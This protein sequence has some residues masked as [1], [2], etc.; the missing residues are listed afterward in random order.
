MLKITL[1][2]VYLLASCAV[3]RLHPSRPLLT[4]CE[5]LD[6]GNGDIDLVCFVDNG[7]FLDYNEIRAFTQSR[8]DKRKFNVSI[9]CA[10]G[11]VLH[12]PWPFSAV[13]VVSLQVTGCETVGFISEM[14]E[15]YPHPNEIKQVS[16]TDITHRITIKELFDTFRTHDSVPSEF[17]CGLN[18]AIVQVFK[19]IKY[20]FPPPSGTIEELR[21][22]EEL[23]S[24]NTMEKLLSHNSICR[25]PYLQYL[26]ESGHSSLSSLRFKL[27]EAT[28]LY[29]ELRYYVLRNNSLI[30]VPNEFRNLA[31]RFLPKLEVLDFSD[32][33]ITELDFQF[34]FSRNTVKPLVVNLRNN[35]VRSLRSNLVDNLLEQG[36]IVLDIRGNPLVCSCELFRYADFLLAQ[37][38]SGSVADLANFTCTHE[39]NG[40]QE[41]HRVS[42]TAFRKTLCNV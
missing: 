38:V 35:K 19:N 41:V 5:Q 37:G 23:M 21:M 29:P 24:R 30:S 15:Q 8:S 16:V 9:N 28:G 6:T 17:D 40:K 14:F 11:G 20:K 39:D 27:M 32:N 33:E 31:L 22:L 3:V 1:T 18:G 7:Q 13:N 10:S 36:N 25:F 34:S 42:E 26:E 4:Q 12:L 2:L